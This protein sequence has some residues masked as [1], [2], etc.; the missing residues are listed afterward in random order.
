MMGGGESFGPP[1]F[2]FKNA[3]M[4]TRIFIFILLA[5]CIFYGHAQTGQVGEAMLSF[6]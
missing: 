6:R 5:S 4:K 2:N 1:F 3:Y